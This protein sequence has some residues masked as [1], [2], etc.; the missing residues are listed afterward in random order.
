MD[1]VV[2]KNFPV[3]NNITIRLPRRDTGIVQREKRAR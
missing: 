1:D 2:A 3:V